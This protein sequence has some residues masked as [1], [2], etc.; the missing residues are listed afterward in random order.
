MLR[1]RR[2]SIKVG[3]GI[4]FSQ[5]EIFY[6]FYPLAIYRVALYCYTAQGLL[7]F[8]INLI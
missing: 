6:K 5:W 2:A 3:I 1:E 8:A 7:T 4:E